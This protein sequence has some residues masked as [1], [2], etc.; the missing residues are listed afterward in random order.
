MSSAPALVVDA[1]R[2]EFAQRRRLFRALAAPVRAVDD[3]SFQVA[4]GET[5]GLVGESGCGKSTLARLIM[6]LTRPTAGAVLVDG[7]TVETLLPSEVLAYRRRV[8]MIFQDP[9]SSLNPRIRAGDLIGEPL[10]IVR[11]NGFRT[12]SRAASVSGLPSPVRLPCRRNSSW[13][14][15]QSPHWTYRCEPRC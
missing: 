7:R 10:R 11:C 15:S 3:V 13:P 5:L 2:K 14:T 6:R 9:S 4:A 1:L 8:Q 12:S